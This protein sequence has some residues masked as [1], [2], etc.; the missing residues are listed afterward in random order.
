LNRRIERASVMRFAEVFL[1]IGSALVAWMV[2]YAHF[3]WLVALSVVGCGPDGDE[4]LRLL[5]GLAPI[6]IGMA[7]VLS[8][9]RPFPEIHSMLRWLGV[10]LLLLLPFAIRSAWLVFSRVVYDSTAACT[11]S[12]PTTWQLVWAPVQIIVVGVAT[13]CVVKVWRTV[14]ADAAAA[15]QEGSL[16]D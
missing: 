16:S 2:L 1:R 12:A 3:L 11:D 4:M 6:T 10:P 8:A 9:T 7:V 5:L 15:E 13:Y 14:K